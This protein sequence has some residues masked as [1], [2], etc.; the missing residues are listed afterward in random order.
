VTGFVAG[1]TCGYIGHYKVHGVLDALNAANGGLPES[2]D[3]IYYVYQ[4]E[5]DVT[6]Q[7]HL[8][9]KGQYPNGLDATRNYKNSSA[10]TVGTVSF[11]NIDGL[12]VITASD[13]M[14]LIIQEDSGNL[15]G[16]RMFAAKLEHDQDGKE[17]DYYLLALGR[18][19][20]NTRAVA[21][22]GIPH[23]T[24]CRGAQANE[25]SGVHDLSG[26]LLKDDYGMFLCSASDD[27]RC[28]RAANQMVA[29]NDKQIIINLQAGELS[30]GVIE[31]FVADR[32]G[33]IYML[34]PN[35]PV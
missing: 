26:Y 19:K 22:V 6:S 16:E 27:G 23:G 17:L 2:M 7:I 13:G 28:I 31:A 20:L 24:N 32:G 33:Q 25:F 35:L 5:L 1:S 14:Y 30:C 10:P 15:Y 4:G 12:E 3:G 34:Q 18:G 29:M 9:G 21:G 11:D 8:G